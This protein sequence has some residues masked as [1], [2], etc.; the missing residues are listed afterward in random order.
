MPSRVT[1]AVEPL[2][3]TV[4]RAALD[5][6]VSIDALG[7]ITEFNPAAERMFEISREEV[8]GLDM[9][10]VIIPPGQRAAHRA[11][12]ARML[13]GG[14][15][16]GARILE[17]R[18]ELE[19]QRADGTLLPVELT[20]TPI[21]GGDGYIGFLRDI[22]ERR[23]IERE[24]AERHARQGLIVA[25]GKSALMA[26]DLSELTREALTTLSEGVGAARAMAVHTDG[27]QGLRRVAAIGLGPL[28]GHGEPV[29]APQARL[30][31]ETAGAGGLLVARGEDLR[32]LEDSGLPVA[33]GAGAVLSVVLRGDRGTIVGLLAVAV[34][35]PDALGPMDEN[36]A[37]AI[38]NVLGGAIARRRMDEE[39]ARLG[40]HDPLTGLPNRPLFENR[41]KVALG[42]SRRHGTEAA[43]M[44]VDLD[45][46]RA[47]NDSFGH[48]TGDDVL[49][50]A[51][52][53]LAALL[54]EE[55]TVA[56]MS[57][58]RFGVL[59]LDVSGEGA[60]LALAGR[61]GEAL[62]APLLAGDREITLTTSVGIA[63]TE[64]GAATVSE[65]MG[66]ATAAVARAK[67]R[68]GDRAELATQAMRRRLIRA[69][70]IEQGVR[71]ALQDGELCLHFQPIVD[72]GS[73][74]A[75]ALEAFV[76]WQHPTLGLLPPAQ[77][78]T[79]A[80]ST[81]LAV[82][83]GNE[84][85]EMACRELARWNAT[86]G[87]DGA[88]AVHVNI[89]ARHFA[90]PG[91]VET[92]AETLRRS[93]ASPRQLVLE[94]AETLFTG[95][96]QAAMIQLQGLRDLGVRIAL[97]RFGTGHSSLAAIR[98]LPFDAMKIDPSF[99]T[100]VDSGSRDAALIGSM[101]DLGH[102]LGLRVTAARVETRAQLV[103]LRTLGLDRAQGEL[104]V[105]PLDADS[106]LEVVRSGRTWAE[107]LD[108]TRPPTRPIP[109][110]PAAAASESAR[111]VPTLSLGQAAQALGVSTTTARR[112]AD[113]GRLG[114]TRTSGG[115]RRFPVSEVRR[116]LSERGRPA[117]RPAEAPK[118]ALQ[119]LAEL[120]AQHGAAV[121]ELAW[122]NLYGDLGAGFFTQP[123]G[124]DA[125]GRWL[126]AM[127]KSATT[128]N[129]EMLD[130]ATAT[131]MAA[132]ERGGASVLER[133]LA[134]E[135]FAEMAVRALS[136]RSCP[137]EEL[138]ETR[139]LF[140]FVA[141]RRLGAA[142]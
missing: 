36:F 102:S 96:G 140:A 58:D 16:S 73:G 44:M 117:V 122:R 14:E 95:D 115:H 55:D 128:G 32:A 38:G 45:G 64:R 86:V 129:Y 76:R 110:A 3:A 111:P 21:G 137:H 53:R 4:L 121:A 75:V 134:L 42:R 1:T 123:E 91:L 138:T 135:R 136:R 20:V 13:E 33:Q 92:V 125:A 61:I 50:A 52:A 116:L 103:L 88:P 101:I 109:A 99:L 107:L 108:D 77:F 17:R 69:A 46:F 2:D 6:I 23:L 104:F 131:L 114:T 65:V 31:Q 34:A 130:E 70:E 63:L 5:A 41:L 98:Q 35:S 26:T 71:R 112:W 37:T 18:V 106:A 118:R 10:E 78:L 89:S 133:H 29:G 142:G 84:V 67:D 94:L 19:A 49:I 139:R 74:R 40:L 8:M 57:S 27:E 79:T 28:A 66:T 62:S 83:L 39:V 100:E 93:G 113:E 54:R 127:G 126:A 119:G 87:E 51:G 105:A 82:P 81:G 11:G 47:L 7:H 90:A 68:G 120:A 60:A 124:S 15:G 30:L 72:L 12:M 22:S 59:L 132:A 9:A 56:R 141:Q 43:V 25:L 80:E 97:D 48:S 85:L 24:R